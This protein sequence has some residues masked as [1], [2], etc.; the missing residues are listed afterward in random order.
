MARQALRRLQTSSVHRALFLSSLAATAAFFA[1]PVAIATLVALG[2]RSA[3][4]AV[5][6]TGLVVVAVG[7]WVFLAA[8][9][10]A[11]LLALAM[12]T[13]GSPLVGRSLRACQVTGLGLAACQTFVGGLLTR[14]VEVIWLLLSMPAGVVGGSV[15]YRSSRVAPA[16]DAR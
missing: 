13:V 1:V 10:E 16:N 6:F 7:P 5:G 11:L 12:R 8:Y 14:E 2:S 9:L 3:G 4:I 15:F